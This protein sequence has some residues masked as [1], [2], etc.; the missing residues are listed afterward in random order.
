MHI[1]SALNIQTISIFGSTSPLANP[2]LA[3]NSIILKKKISCSPCFKST[4][5]IMVTII[6]LSRN[7]SR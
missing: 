1:A 4:Y 5:A 2:P 3:D 7:F 6:A